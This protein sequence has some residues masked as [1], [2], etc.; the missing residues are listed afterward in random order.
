M[1]LL[2]FKHQWPFECHH[3]HIF[4]VLLQVD[5]LLL[6]GFDL[7]LQVHAAHVGVIDEL[8]Q[9]D[10]V[11]L[12]GLAD[13]QLGLVSKQHSTGRGIDDKFKDWYVCSDL[14]GIVYG[15]L[16]YTY[17]VWVNDWCYCMLSQ[18]NIDASIWPTWAKRDQWRPVKACQQMRFWYIL[19]R[20]QS[21]V[22]FLVCLHR[23]R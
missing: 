5:E 16:Y 6:Q 17:T 8:P 4:V 1:H 10:D 12:H 15:L 7:A 21:K 2:S 18:Y 11:G 22:D 9:P 20:H 14:H 19:I 3:T 23:G 13:R